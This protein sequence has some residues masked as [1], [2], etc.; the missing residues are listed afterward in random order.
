MRFP[1]SDAEIESTV[2]SPE[3]RLLV[4]L[5][6][7]AVFDYFG[8]RAAER[9]AAEEW[10]FAEDVDATELFS[11]NWVCTQLD[12]NGP[13]ILNRLSSIGSL[14]LKAENCDDRLDALFQQVA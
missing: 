14:A 4:A 10:F 12:F 9:A 8:S 11:F 7:R 5:L 13:Q 6:R 2:P 1:H 3:K